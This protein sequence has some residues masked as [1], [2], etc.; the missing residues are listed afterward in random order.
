MYKDILDIIIQLSLGQHIT[1]L[2]SSHILRHDNPFK[3]M[4][5][6]FNRWKKKWSE[7]F[8]TSKCVRSG[9]I[10]S[11]TVLIKNE[12]NFLK[13]LKRGKNVLFGPKLGQLPGILR[14]HKEG[15]DSGKKHLVQG[16]PCFLCTDK[17]SWQR[18]F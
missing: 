14:L 11:S 6:L 8:S 10:S 1:F 16:Y 18:T 2:G 3:Q 17:S 12:Q 13:I 7:D 15:S 4:S 9:L 5:L